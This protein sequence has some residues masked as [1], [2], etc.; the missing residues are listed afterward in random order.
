M[1]IKAVVATTF[2]DQE[3]GWSYSD[4]ALKSLADSARGK[5]V[6]HQKK[7]VGEVTSSWH[8]DGK[9]MVEADINNSEAIM[10]RTLFL[11]PGGLT[12]FDTIGD[13]LDSCKAHQFFFTDQPSDQTLTPFEVVN[14]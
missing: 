6:S 9:A 5:P 4:A 8:E 10:N 1:K 12:D 14:P 2:R 13:V 3:N 11:V 7:R